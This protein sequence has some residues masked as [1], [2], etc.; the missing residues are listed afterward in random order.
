V[1][2]ADWRKEGVGYWHVLEKKPTTSECNPPPETSLISGW[3]ICQ[4]LTQK[5]RL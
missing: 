5:K 2:P 3:L 1:A 4:N